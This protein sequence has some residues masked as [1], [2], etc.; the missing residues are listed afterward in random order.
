M[1]NKSKSIIGGMTVLGLAGVICKLVGVLYSIP[2]TWMIGT[3]GLGVYQAVFPAYNLM[4]TISSAG[5]P[6]AVSRL[7]ARSLELTGNPCGV[8]FEKTRLDFRPG[9]SLDGIKNVTEFVSSNIL[10]D[11]EEYAAEVCEILKKEFD[12]INPT[13]N[14]RCIDITAAGV[15]KASGIATLAQIMGVAE[16]NVW[17]AG[18]NYNDIDMLLK[19]HGCAME[20]GVEAAKK[21]AEYTCD[22]VA[23]VIKMIM[24]VRR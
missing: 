14:G 23:D 18:D 11:T 15:G 9:D 7:V 24:D 22:T 4:L 21:A 19:Y 10:C 8:S 1:S 12:G 2:L 5:L 6:V 20:S 17:T 3:D 16:E 13:Q